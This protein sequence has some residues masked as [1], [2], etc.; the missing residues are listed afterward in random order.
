L[1]AVELA[2]IGPAD[3]DADTKKKIVKVV[4]KVAEELGNTP[5]VCRGSY[6]HPVVLDAYANGITLNEFQANKKRRIKRVQRGLEPEEAALL[7]LF[8][9]GNGSS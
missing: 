5:A 3:S 6:I 7:K 4:K 1:T 8:Q 2:E 9:N